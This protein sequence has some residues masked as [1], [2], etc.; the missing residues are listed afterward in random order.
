MSIRSLN[1]LF[2][3]LLYTFIFPSQGICGNTTWKNEI[4]SLAKGGAVLVVDEG[5]RELYSLNPAKPLIPASTLKIFTAAAALNFMGSDFHF[6]TEF[7]LSPEKDLYVIGRGD[8]C[9]ISEELSIIAGKLKSKGLNEVR[10]ILLDDSYFQPGQMLHGARR[11]LNPY[12]AFNGALSVNFNTVMVHIDLGGKVNSGEPQTP[13]TAIARTAALK[14]GLKGKI[15]LNLAESPEICLLYSGELLRKFLEKS[16]IKVLGKVAR[17]TGNHKKHPIYFNHKSR[18]DLASILEKMFKYSNNFIANQVF[19]TMGAVKEPP[20]ASVEK[21]RR[22]MGRFLSN[23]GISGLRLE[24]GSGLSRRNR[25]TAAQMIK[26]LDYF[27]P[28]RHLLTRKDRT[29]FK[30]GTLRNVASMAGYLDPG[31]TGIFSFVVILNGK[32]SCVRSRD[33]IMA[34]LKKNLIL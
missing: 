15:R 3:F 2:I 7:R 10:D 16:S 30:T 14:T 18:G 26:V 22:V 8:P 28:Y 9:L 29:W 6:I 33:R 31:H 27:R 21:S 20:P 4:R 13:L 32:R 34:L 24:E 19:L 11:S 5:G 17:A 25:V 12:D 23:I 1:L